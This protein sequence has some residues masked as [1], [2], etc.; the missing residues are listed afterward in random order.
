MPESFTLPDLDDLLDQP[1]PAGAAGGATAPEPPSV[2]LTRTRWLTVRWHLASPTTMVAVAAVVLIAA[3]SL[4]LWVLRSA[5][6]PPS[7][8]G[9]TAPASSVSSVIAS[10][11][12][13]TLDPTP[14]TPGPVTTVKV[15]E[16]V[17]VT[18][19]A[20]AQ[21]HATTPAPAGPTLEPAVAPQTAQSS[22]Q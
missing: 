8:D 12:A 11:T 1:D 21:E 2:R 20:A 9:V 22:I 14:S 19:T 3:A 10:T 4:L 17:T 18:F 16:Y 13:A 7:P 6:P 15:T 5:D